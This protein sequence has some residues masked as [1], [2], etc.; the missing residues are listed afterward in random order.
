LLRYKWEDDYL[1]GS[2]GW[3]LGRP[4]PVFS[5]LLADRQLPP[6]RMLVVCAGRGHDTCTALRAVQCRCAREFARHGYQVTAVDFSP[7]AAQEMSR[8]AGPD[9]P[10]EILQQDL[11]TLPHELD[12][13][14]DYVLE[15]EYTCDC[16][17][18]PKRRAEFVDL[19]ARLLKP[20]GIYISLTFPLTQ[21][22]GP[23]FAVTVSELLGLF[24]E[25]GFQLIEREK[26]TD[27]VPSVGA[28]KSCSCFKRRL[29]RRQ[30]TDLRVPRMGYCQ[31]GHAPP[32]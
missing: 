28:P 20:G 21:Q 5:N 9:T 8:L 24:Q 17:I 32:W 13:F 19:V 6:G 15:L 3:D 12:G 29:S 18:D 14:F 31:A 16:A 10:V 2:D 26:P 4:T 22:G 11:F 1:R 27:S 25:R 7:L 30:A 23:P